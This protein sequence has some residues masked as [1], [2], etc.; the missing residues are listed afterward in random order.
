MCFFLSYLS[1]LILCC[2]YLD[3]LARI[4]K[5]KKLAPDYWTEVSTGLFEDIV[6][7]FMLSNV[8]VLLIFFT[9]VNP[10]SSG[11][12]RKPWTTS[13][14][15]IL[16]TLRFRLLLMLAKWLLVLVLLRRLKHVLA[17]L[18]YLFILTSLFN[19]SLSL[20]PA[21]HYILH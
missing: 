14:M 4:D 19:D 7:V 1:F 11:C 10:T 3:F 15:I 8:V 16:I 21:S 2:S 5:L 13:L 6:Y 18:L 20:L 17:L 9:A 12:F